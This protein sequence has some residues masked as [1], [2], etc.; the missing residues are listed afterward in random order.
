M[1][2][3]SGTSGRH[4]APKP[5]AVSYEPHTVEVIT[6]VQRHAG[7]RSRWRSVCATWLFPRDHVTHDDLGTIDADDIH[8]HRS[9]R[10]ASRTDGPIG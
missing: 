5:S 3:F 8:R 6:S 10:P 9:E 4:L 2:A 1:C 7:G